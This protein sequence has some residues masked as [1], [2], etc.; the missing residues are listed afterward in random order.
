MVTHT[1]NL[2]SAFIPSKVHT[3]SSEHTPGAVGSHLCCGARGAVG[4]SVPCSRAPQSW[5]WRWRERC[6]F[7][8]PTYNPCRTWDSNPRPLGYES[9]SLTIRPQLP[10]KKKGIFCNIMNVFTA[11]V[12]LNYSVSSSHDVCKIQTQG[13]CM[14]SE[15]LF[16]RLLFKIIRLTNFRPYARCK[17]SILWHCSLSFR[18][19]AAWSTCP[20]WSRRPL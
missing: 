20:S 9:N 19:I 1:R 12:N 15:C 5:Y 7:T 2:C 11:T 16:W 6:T 4:G 14:A 13:Y 3:H 18:C 10:L 17:Q 8:P